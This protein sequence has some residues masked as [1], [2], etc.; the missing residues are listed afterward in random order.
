[1]SRVVCFSLTNKSQP[2]IST[3]HHNT[4]QYITIEEGSNLLVLREFERDSVVHPL[5]LL[6][7]PQHHLAAVEGLLPKPA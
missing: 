5:A 4:A 6:D 2:T 3:T 1:M 7:V